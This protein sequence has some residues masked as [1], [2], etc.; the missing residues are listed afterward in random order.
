[1]IERF[2]TSDPNKKQR[3]KQTAVQWLLAKTELIKTGYS[4]IPDTVSPNYPDILGGMFYY[5]YD[6]K[7]KDKL[8]QW[9]K[10]PLVIILEKYADGFLGLNLHYVSDNVRASLL[11]TLLNYRTY[12]P[13]RDIMKINARYKTLSTL[14]SIP[15]FK[16]CIKRYLT[17]QIRGKV[18]LIRPHE[19]GMAVMLPLQEFIQK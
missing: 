10:F 16:Y 3:L 1:M 12:D 13:Q 5:H 17:N 19:W 9:D 6:P 2:K 8:K 11:T 7:T 14:K 4:D 15:D 18:L